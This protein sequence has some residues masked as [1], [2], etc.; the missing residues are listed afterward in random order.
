MTSTTS[1]VT[2]RWTI[3]WSTWPH[4]RRSI[5]TRSPTLTTIWCLKWRSSMF[6]SYKAVI[7]SFCSNQSCSLDWLIECFCTCTCS[8]LF[9][10]MDKVHVYFG[11]TEQSLFRMNNQS[12]NFD[13][14]VECLCSA[15]L[16]IPWNGWWKSFLCQIRKQFGIVRGK[17]CERGKKLSELIFLFTLR[18]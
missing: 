18:A 2:G 1:N 3:S 9:S 17:I 16:L 13:R 8:A 14:L 12:C 15:H 7:V 10:F 5:C 6:C 4:H 11:L